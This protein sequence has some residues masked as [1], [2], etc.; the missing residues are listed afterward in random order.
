MITLKHFKVGNFNGC[1]T[2]ENNE[3][4]GIVAECY[5]RGWDKPNYQMPAIR[6]ELDYYRN[7][8]TNEVVAVVLFNVSDPINPCLEFWH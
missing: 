7:W 2:T 5:A 3:P 1:L 6:T 8:P 4:L